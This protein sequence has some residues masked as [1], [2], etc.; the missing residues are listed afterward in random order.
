MS[1]R[2][3]G[4][5]PESILRALKSAR[6]SGGRKNRP[7]AARV[8]ARGKNEA[9]ALLSA[10][11]CCAPAYARNTLFY[12]VALGHV[13]PLNDAGPNI[14]L[15]AVR[16]AFC[17]FSRAST[18]GYKNVISTRRAH[19]LNKRARAEFRHRP[20]DRRIFHAGSNVL[21]MH[22]KFSGHKKKY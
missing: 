15:P 1:N 8:R 9:H 18:R 13:P 5:A 11:G 3:A 4:A 16:C 20:N 10:G 2:R 21:F 7:R 17:L 14:S 12:N 19:A 22:V 6:A